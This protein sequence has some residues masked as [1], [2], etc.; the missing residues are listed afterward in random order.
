M[1]NIIF[2]MDGAVN[3]SI[4]AANEA[5]VKM[6]YRGNTREEVI[7][8]HLHYCTNKPCIPKI[9]FLLKKD[10]FENSLERLEELYTI[11]SAKI[12]LIHHL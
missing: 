9:V 10:I 5:F 8:A 12:L 1:K 7:A 11:T 6:K 3:G 4:H 2:D